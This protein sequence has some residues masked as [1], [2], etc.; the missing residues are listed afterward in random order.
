MSYNI[1]TRATLSLAEAKLAIGS[2]N[3]RKG[4]KQ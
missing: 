3:N 1:K 4:V 2:D